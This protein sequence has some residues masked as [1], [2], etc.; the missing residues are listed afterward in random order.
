LWSLARNH[1]FVDENK[2]TPWAAVATVLVE[3]LTPQT[4]LIVDDKLRPLSSHNA[5]STEADRD[6]QACPIG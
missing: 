1:A 3:R 4:W 2:R 5:M 6:C